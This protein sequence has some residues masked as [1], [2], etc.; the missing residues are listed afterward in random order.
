MNVH[1]VQSAVVSRRLCSAL[2]CPPILYV[3]RLA[4]GWRPPLLL[5]PA[6]CPPFR[7]NLTRT[8]TC[9]CKKRSLFAT[10]ILSVS[11]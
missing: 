11:W 7:T 9:P 6:A 3:A 4:K 5:V 2:F 8:G 1:F 10:V